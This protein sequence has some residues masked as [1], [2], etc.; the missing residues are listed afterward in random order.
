[1]LR[2]EGA[3]LSLDFHF[4]PSWEVGLKV[5]VRPYPTARVQT[6]TSRRKKW[7]IQKKLI[8]RY[9]YKTVRLPYNTDEI[10]VDQGRGIVYCYPE[11]ELRLRRE[12][13]SARN[14]PLTSYLS[15]A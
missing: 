7:R 4:A 10:L 6:K 11:M 2:S 14:Y 9:G 5:I 1:V 13:N 3:L 8:K 15:G 12:L